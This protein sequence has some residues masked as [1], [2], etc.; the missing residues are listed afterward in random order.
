[1]PQ[2]TSDFISS[3][4]DNHKTQIDILVL[5]TLF[6]FCSHNTHFGL[7]EAEELI[8]ELKP[9]KVFLVG[10]SCD[11]VPPHDEANALLAKRFSDIETS[12]ELAYD[13]LMLPVDL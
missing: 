1:M 5:D 13:G 4:T 6:F 8:R 2:E 11:E 7:K 10:M 3:W 9:K 12:V